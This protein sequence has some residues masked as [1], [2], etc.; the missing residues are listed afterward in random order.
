MRRKW[1]WS[2]KLLFLL[3]IVLALGATLLLRDHL[4]RIEARAA[5]GGPGGPVLVAAIDLRRGDLVS[6][7]S[8]STVSMPAR[9]TP[10]GA[11]GASREVVGR[12]LATGIAAGEPITVTRLAPEGGPVA[13]LV[14]PGLRAFVVPVAVP[15]GLVEAGDRVDVLATYAGGEPHTET[16][17]SSAEVLAILDAGRGALDST[18]MVVL[19]VST[20]TA[21][22]LAYARSFAEL[23][24]SVTAAQETS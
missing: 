20:D 5:S 10:P 21:E 16:V 8:V 13:A 11:L 18:S 22:R 24:I 19:L 4:A 2:A 7:E 23:T 17:V 6:E 3:S 12:K 15:P 9:Y 14:P 1:P